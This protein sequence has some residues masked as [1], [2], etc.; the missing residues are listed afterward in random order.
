MKNSFEQQEPPVSPAKA[1]KL[2]KKIKDSIDETLVED[3]PNNL[4][5][6]SSFLLMCTHWFEVSAPILLRGDVSNL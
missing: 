4:C 3:G 5:V 2:F 6:C 1:A